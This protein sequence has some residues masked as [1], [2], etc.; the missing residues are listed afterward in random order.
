MVI[1]SDSLLSVQ[2]ISRREINQFE[3]GH[4]IESCRQL[5]NFRPSCSL[6]FVKRQSNKVAHFMVRVPCLLNC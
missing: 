6:S 2:A 1:E 3:I 5:L 4:V